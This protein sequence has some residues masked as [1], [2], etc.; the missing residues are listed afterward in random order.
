MT[1]D[2]IRA[3][4][5]AIREELRALPEFI[6]DAPPVPIDPGMQWMYGLGWFRSPEPDRL[7]RASRVFAAIQYGA[8]VEAERLIRSI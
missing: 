2:E 8:W 6:G 3:A 5:A 7:K 4:A 1:R